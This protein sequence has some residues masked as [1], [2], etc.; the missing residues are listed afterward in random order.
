M[1]LLSETDL[2]TAVEA[3]GP[4][5]DLAVV[6]SAQ[7]LLWANYGR[8]K[9]PGIARLSVTSPE[10]GLRIVIPDGQRSLNALKLASIYEDGL[11]LLP[12]SPA[13]RRDLTAV[14][15]PQQVGTLLGRS[16]GLGI[17]MEPYLAR[18]ARD[19]LVRWHTERAMDTR[20]WTAAQ[21]A[22]H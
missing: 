19:A 8:D 13:M 1:V 7:R 21:S 4:S 3:L 18:P 2:A 15:S 16:Q 12:D 6:W 14:A 20:T 10:G 9:M 22:P 11:L 5:Q 17:L